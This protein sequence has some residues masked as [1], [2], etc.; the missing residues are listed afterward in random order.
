M[1]QAD[2]LLSFLQKAPKVMTVIM[3]GFFSVSTI[4]HQST[5][6]PIKHITYNKKKKSKAEI[7]I[8]IEVYL[9]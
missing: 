3:A 5:T 4:N 7:G 6:Q 1:T 9:L 8:G 2:V